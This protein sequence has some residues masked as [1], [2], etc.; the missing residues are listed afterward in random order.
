V[1][2]RLGPDATKLRPKEKCEAEARYY[3]AEARDVAKVIRILYM[4]A[5]TPT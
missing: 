1:R 2:P 4:N 5:C 3:E